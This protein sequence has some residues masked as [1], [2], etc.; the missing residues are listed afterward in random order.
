M[1]EYVLHYI[2]E[3]NKY[4]SQFFHLAHESSFRQF[5]PNNSLKCLCNLNSFGNEIFFIELSSEE[6][7]IEAFNLL[8]NQFFSGAMSIGYVHIL[9]DTPSKN[10]ILQEF[11]KRS[12]NRK[13]PFPYYHV[14]EQTHDMS[15]LRV[16]P[17]QTTMIQYVP[18]EV[19]RTTSIMKHLPIDHGKGPKC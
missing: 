14:G 1:N 3:A 18:K 2:G 12:E 10:Y 11:T 13:N 16:L 7:E 15:R 5:R 6:R 4:Y 19:R 8:R 9:D 17:P